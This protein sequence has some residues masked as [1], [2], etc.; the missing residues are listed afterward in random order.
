MKYRLTK[1]SIEQ[2]KSEKGGFNIKVI[3]FLTN[4]EDSKPTKGWK[5]RAIG[6]VVKESDYISIYNQRNS[7]LKNINPSSNKKRISTLKK[8]REVLERKTMITNLKKEHIVMKSGWENISDKALRS[9]YNR[10]FF[11]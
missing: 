3:K 4:N 1:H 11:E 7:H 5:T 6:M 8:Q 2:L 9:L 10:V